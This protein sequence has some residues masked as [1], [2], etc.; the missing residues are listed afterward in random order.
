MKAVFGLD[1][2]ELIDQDGSPMGRK[3]FICWNCPLIDPLDPSSRRS[4]PISEASRLLFTLMRKGVRTIVFCKIRKVCDLLLR[5]VRVELSSHQLEELKDK[6]VSYR[7]GY[8]PQDRRRIEQ[9]MFN[10]ELLGIIATNALE[11]GVDIGSL[12]ISRFLGCSLLIHL[13][14]VLILGFPYTISA[15]A[16]ASVINN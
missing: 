4:S 15:L 12:G 16:S 11:L 8:T 3:E 9:A 6:V 2:V 7:G 5:S 13:D 1:N 14:A 10:G